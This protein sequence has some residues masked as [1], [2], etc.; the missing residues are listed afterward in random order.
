MS[1]DYSQRIQQ[2]LVN[3]VK[4]IPAE[5][6]AVYTIAMT[7]VPATLTGALFIAIPLAILVPFYLKFK[8]DVNNTTQIIISS[9]AFIVWLFALG[10]PFI[11]FSWYE[12]WMGGALLTLFTIIPPILLGQP[13]EITTE[14]GGKKKKKMIT[15]SWRQI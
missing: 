7:F 2:Y 12:A 5:I 6:L 13:I 9:L 3:L 11:Y 15:K 10:G 8:L 14:T 4:L 1:Y